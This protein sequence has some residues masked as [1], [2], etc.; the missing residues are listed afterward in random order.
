MLIWLDGWAVS[1]FSFR[2]ALKRFCVVVLSSAAGV[3]S[4]LVS[5]TN[6]ESLTKSLV[7][8]GI[9]N[10]LTVVLSV[11]ISCRTSPNFVSV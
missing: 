1:A 3:V 4:S 5:V 8:A 7:F 9:F 10:S 11:S 6:P 2:I